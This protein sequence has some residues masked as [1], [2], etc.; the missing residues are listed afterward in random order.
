MKIKE[1]SFEV[2]EER[3]RTVV[4]VKSKKVIYTMKVSLK[5]GLDKEKG[6]E[7]IKYLQDNISDIDVDIF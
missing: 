3:G 7:L 6:K 4:I 5:E 2:S 1:V